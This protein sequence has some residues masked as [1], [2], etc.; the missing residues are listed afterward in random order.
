MR[1]QLT[2]F[3][4]YLYVQNS[5]MVVVLVSS[6]YISESVQNTNV[7]HYGNIGDLLIYLT[8]FHDE[9]CGLQRN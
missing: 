1:Q 9:K 8:S 6:K 3:S 7:Y 5:S 2:A 4:R